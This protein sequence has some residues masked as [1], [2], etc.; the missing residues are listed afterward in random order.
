MHR[1]ILYQ[2]PSDVT[3]KKEDIPPQTITPCLKKESVEVLED[4]S[5]NKQILITESLNEI[6]PKN[7]EEKEC[8]LPVEVERNVY[9]F[10][11]KK[12][13]EKHYKKR[14]VLN[15]T[16][17][18]SLIHTVLNIEPIE[19]IKILADPDH[20][21]NKGCLGLDEKYSNIKILVANSDFYVRFNEE[22]NMLKDLNID[23]TKCRN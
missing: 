9:K 11:Y 21:Q 1:R 17:L 7:D 13:R 2:I 6:S 18:R 12:L 10:L 19:S 23:I 22:A 4:G 15:R 8:E 14:L 20:V 5:I 3:V 16:E